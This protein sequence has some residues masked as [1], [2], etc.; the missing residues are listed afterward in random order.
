APARTSRLA[1]LFAPAPGDRP[2]AP[3]F[4]RIKA[5][6]ASV[7]ANPAESV[8]A[9]APPRPATGQDAGRLDLRSMA[10]LGVVSG[11]EGRRALLRLPSGAV[12]RVSEGQEVDGWRVSAIDDISVR[13]VDAGRVR[14]LTMP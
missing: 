5:P 13:I 9:G 10:L 2:Q 14:T 3:S 7:P 12:R 1:A 11:P 6:P 8:A 4:K